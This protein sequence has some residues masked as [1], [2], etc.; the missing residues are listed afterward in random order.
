MVW[1]ARA[2][3]KHPMERTVSQKNTWGLNG[4]G[5]PFGMET[6]L[7]WLVTGPL[8]RAKWPGKPVRDGNRL[9]LVYLR[10]ELMGKRAGKAGS[11]G[12]RV[13]DNAGTRCSRAQ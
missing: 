4:L 12:K 3:W 1:G 7:F 13:S 8:A 6:A 5:S 2:G 10:I 9:Q 11:E